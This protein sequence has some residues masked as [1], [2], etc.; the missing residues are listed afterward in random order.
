MSSLI[1]NSTMINGVRQYYGY[2]IKIKLPQQSV[3]VSLPESKDREHYARD[4]QQ[5]GNQIEQEAKENPHQRSH[6]EWVKYIYSRFG[7]SEVLD[8]K[9][10]AKEVRQAKENH[11]I[12]LDEAFTK[13]IRHKVQLN[14]IQSER[15]IRLYNRT[16]KYMIECLGNIPIGEYTEKVHQRFFNYLKK[17]KMNDTTINIHQRGIKS[18]MN[19]CFKKHLIDKYVDIEMITK[20]PPKENNY[21]SPEQ[22]DEICSN[23]SKEMASY[24]KIAYHTGLRLR[25]LNTDPECKEALGLYHILESDDQGDYRIRVFGKGRK[26]GYVSLPNGLLSTYKVLQHN[27]FKPGSIT[28]NFKRACRKSGYPQFHFHNL[29]ASFGDNLIKSGNDPFVIMKAMRHSSLA[30][31]DHY[32]QDEEFGWQQLKSNI[33]LKCNGNV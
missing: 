8:K 11:V 15:T 22:L 31:T 4:K 20:I 18:V 5:I 9:N 19:W 12:R 29:R 21:I 16:C 6:Q 23:T 14:H 30:V 2:T 3:R 1:K 26:K 28:I 33:I 27:H 24:F 10:Q 32:I 7:I 13:M 17:Q 25:E